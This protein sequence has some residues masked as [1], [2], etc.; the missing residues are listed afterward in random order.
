MYSYLM[1][2]YGSVQYFLKNIMFRKYWKIPGFLQ[3]FIIYSTNLGTTIVN[4]SSIVIIPTTDRMNAGG[5]IVESSLAFSSLSYSDSGSYACIAMRG[6][7]SAVNLDQTF[8][9]DIIASPQITFLTPPSV[10]VV[11]TYVTLN[12]QASGVPTP[13]IKWSNSAGTE[14]GTTSSISVRVMNAG[15]NT[16]FCEATNAGGYDTDNTSVTGYT[17][18]AT[19]TTP[20]GDSTVAYRDK[21]SF[22][23]ETS[24]DPV[25]SVKWHLTGSDGVEVEVTADDEAYT[26]SDSSLVIQR[27]TLK[28]QGVY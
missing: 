19:I 2:L 23:C 8:T 21:A 25:P 22:M 28:E 3:I 26:I 18:T 6:G 12:C 7:A 4:S 9:L 20:P 24:G 5:I 1:H 11:G 16:W 14:I 17:T 15:V 13:T 27:P 10:A